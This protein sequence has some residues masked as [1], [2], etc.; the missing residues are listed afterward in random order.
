MVSLRSV[1][2]EES[3]VVVMRG[4][5]IFSIKPEDLDPQA[6]SKRFILHVDILINS[7][8]SLRLLA[9]LKMEYKRL[10]GVQMIRCS[11]L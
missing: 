5:D 11:S 2:G 4:G 10:H 1:V 8:L 9:L 3:L 7:S 6:R